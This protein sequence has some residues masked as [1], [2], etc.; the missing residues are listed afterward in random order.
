MTK[1][2]GSQVLLDTIAELLATAP[3]PSPLNRR[4]AREPSA[5]VPA[6]E[7]AEPNRQVSPPR[8]QEGRGDAK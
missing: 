8:H 1:P 6:S 7:A 2:P 4:R 3:A 5:D